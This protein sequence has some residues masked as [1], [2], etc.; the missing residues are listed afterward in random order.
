M[1]VK[2]GEEFGDLMQFMPE[3]LSANKING[4]I[5]KALEDA[6]EEEYDEEDA[7]VEDDGD[8]EEEAPKA[9]KAAKAPAKAAGKK[10]TSDDTSG[11]TDYDNNNAISY[12]CIS[13]HTVAKVHKNLHIYLN[14]AT[15]LQI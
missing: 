10:A 15:L 5:K 13:C 11:D 12:L 8:E 7:D 3:N 4:T 14:S 2:A 9:K 1:A 6:G